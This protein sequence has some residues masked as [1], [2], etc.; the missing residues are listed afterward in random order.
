MAVSGECDIEFA[1]V[2]KV[3]EDHAG[4][5]IADRSDICRRKRERCRHRWDRGSKS[6]GSQNNFEHHSCPDV[7]R[8]EV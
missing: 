2:I 6:G 4:R 8:V 3:S 1:I 7:F 5:S